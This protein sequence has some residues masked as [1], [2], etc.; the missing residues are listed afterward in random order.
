MSVKKNYVALE[1]IVRKEVFR[2]LRIWQQS[3]LPPVVTQTIYFLIFGN[4]IGS[5]VS[6]I[7]GVN[8]MSFIVPGLI[9]MSVINASY[10]NVVGSFFSSKFQRSVEEMMVSPMT[11]FVIV[12]GYV[13]GGSLRGLLVGTIVFCVSTFFIRPVIHNGW[14]VII[15]MILTSILFSLGGFLNAIYAKKFDDVSVFSSFILTPLIYLGGVFYSISQLPIF[16][17]KVSRLN[18]ILYIINGFRLGFYGITDVNG[19]L[20][21]IIVCLLIILLIWV[22]V[23]LLKKG[24]GLR[25]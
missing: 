20:S 13:I 18:P 14:L 17:Q 1:T 8:Y 5:Q 24:T 19:N 2:F 15:F 3:L 21:L 23:F 22:N 25:I 11:E 16:W 7:Q 10:T 12:M 9:M 4:F 6:D